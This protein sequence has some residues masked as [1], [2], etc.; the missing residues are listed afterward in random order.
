MLPKP[1][2]AKID[3]R[4]HF[5]VEKVAQLHICAT[6]VILTKTTQSK[7]SLNRQKFAQSGHPAVGKPL[8]MTDPL[9]ATFFFFTH[10]RRQW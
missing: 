1:F 5:T 2:F 8:K 6:S 9:F 3:A 4:V 7:Q 10:R